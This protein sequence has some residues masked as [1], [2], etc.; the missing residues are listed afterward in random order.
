MVRGLT[1]TFK[2]VAEK[3]EVFSFCLSYLVTVWGNVGA[4][5]V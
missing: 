4:E 2:G 1:D 3:M 5:E